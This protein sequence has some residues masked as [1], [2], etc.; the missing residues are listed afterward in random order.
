MASASEQIFELRGD[1]AKS[2]PGRMADH[3]WFALEIRRDLD[4]GGAAEADHFADVFAD[5]VR[6]D[7]NSGDE[8]HP[9]FAEQQAS[10]LRSDWTDS[11]LR[12]AHRLH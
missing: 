3:F 7:I 4:A 5:F 2:R 10:D 11:V 9:W 12:D 8:F 1:F 6:V